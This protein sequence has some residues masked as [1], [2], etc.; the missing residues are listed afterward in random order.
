MKEVRNIAAYYSR[1]PHFARLLKELR[2]RYPEARLTAITPPGFPQ[3]ALIGQADRMIH[4]SQAVYG[5]HEPG[6][7]FSLVGQ[8]RK[9]KYDLFV[10]MFDSPKLRM[11]AALSG[12]KR[13]ACYTTS[14]DYTP[15]GLSPFRQVFTMIYRG[16]QGRIRYRRI[17]RIVYTQPVKPEKSGQ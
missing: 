7:L 8:L 1:G 11:L 2:K 17:R 6:A 15:L 5:L 13:R 12:A 9:G 4:T 10:V 3:E 16:L 14:G